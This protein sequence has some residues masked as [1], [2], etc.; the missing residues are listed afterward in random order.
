MACHAGR[1][2]TRLG[3]GAELRGRTVGDAALS[4]PTVFASGAR[5]AELAAFFEDG[6]DGRR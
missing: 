6:G 3:V 5:V 2:A 1:S 4:A